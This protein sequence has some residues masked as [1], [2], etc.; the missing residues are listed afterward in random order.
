MIVTDMHVGNGD[1]SEYRVNIYAYA[2]WI[3]R[4]SD[5]HIIRSFGNRF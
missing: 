5:D 4:I 2:E 1:G 3:G